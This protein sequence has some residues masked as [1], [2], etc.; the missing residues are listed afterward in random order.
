[1]T[2]Y[3]AAAASVPRRSH[4]QASTGSARAWRRNQNTAKFQLRDGLGPV[5]STVLVI[6]LLSVL[7]LIYLTQ[8]TKTS[9]YGYQIN[10]LREQRAELQDKQAALQV[11]TARLQSLQR[12]QESDVAASMVA[13]EET[14]QAN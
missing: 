12:A 8:I 7:G 1:M 10:E 11:E 14:N 9:N 13:P 4:A 5:T 3:Y 2:Q 6:L